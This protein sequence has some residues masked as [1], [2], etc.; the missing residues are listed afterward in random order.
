M[1]A[2]VLVMLF[3]LPLLSL[4]FFIV[5]LYD[6]L[7]ARGDDSVSPE[8]RKRCRN[9]FIAASVTAVVIGLILWGMVSIVFGSI[10]F[11]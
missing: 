6:Y 2:A 9:R 10:S 1:L 11:M 7:S 5:S 8:E 4:I 3:F